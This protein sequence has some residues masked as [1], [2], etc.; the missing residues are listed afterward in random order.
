MAFELDFTNQQVIC[1]M[2]DFTTGNTGSQTLDY[3][4][5]TA[6]DFYATGGISF[7]GTG[8]GNLTVDDILAMDVITAG[9]LPDPCIPAF[10]PC[11]L[12]FRNGYNGYAGCD[13]TYLATSGDFNSYANG[14]ALNYFKA[15]YPGIGRYGALLRFNDLFGPGRVR[16]PTG[17]AV[18]KSLLP[19]RHCVLFRYGQYDNPGDAF[20]VDFRPMYSDWVE[21][22][23][24][25]GYVEGASCMHAR[26]Y[27][28]SDDYSNPG[29]CWGTSAADNGSGP[30]FNVDYD[31]TNPVGGIYTVGGSIAPV[32]GQT[33][34]YMDVDVTGLCRPG[35]MDPWTISGSMPKAISGRITSCTIPVNIPI[36]ISAPR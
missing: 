14:G 22:D 1:S 25:G 9:D 16:C 21:G 33:Y 15:S 2:T 8:G 27:R 5:G 10:D 26:K 17:P 11:S 30:V 36:R 20:R 18:M 29:D 31:Y 7:R 23:G 35:A 19:K 3:A 6:G 12:V 32:F 28:G 34:E 24:I 4:L 13:D